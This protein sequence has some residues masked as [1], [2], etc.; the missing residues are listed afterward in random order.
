[1]ITHRLNQD[2]SSNASFYYDYLQNLLTKQSIKTSDD[3]N[4]EEWIKENLKL[5]CQQVYFD[6]SG[7]KLNRSSTFLLKEKYY[8]LNIPFVED[9]LV[10]AGVRLARLLNRIV[11]ERNQLKPTATATTTTSVVWRKIWIF[12]GIGVSAAVIVFIGLICVV[13]YRKN[14]A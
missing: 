7:K 5:I 13:I 3:D 12:I 11:S 10:H 2:F 4:I 9:R 8:E 14:K 1:M 6:E